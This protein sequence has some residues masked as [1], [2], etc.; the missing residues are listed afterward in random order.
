MKCF[1]LE[2]PNTF[3]S[4]LTEE[5]EINK[6]RT[7]RSL[8]IIS[9]YGVRHTGR[10]LGYLLLFE[11]RTAQYGEVRG[12]VHHIVHIVL[13]KNNVRN[14]KKR[15]IILGFVVNY[16]RIS[17]ILFGILLTRNFQD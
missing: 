7:K 11:W 10:M 6:N 3:L 1:T 8:V 2:L 5:K 14:V 13:I 17:Q 12:A 4:Y 16:L 9:N 15:I